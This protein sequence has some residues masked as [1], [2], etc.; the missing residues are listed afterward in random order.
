MIGT[1]TDSF[2]IKIGEFE[3]PFELLLDLV[4]RKKLP[5]N[6][7]SLSAIT[8]DFVAQLEGLGQTGMARLADFLLIASTL[9]LIKS[10]SLLPTLAV[11]EEETLGIEDLER[12]LK[13]YQVIKNAAA[14]LREKMGKTPIFF[15]AHPEQVV[16]FTPTAEITIIR[17]AATINDVLH[18]LPKAERLPEVQVTK[19]ITLEEMITDLAKRIERAMATSFRDLVKD[20]KDKINVIVGFLALLELVK[21]GVIE[22]KQHQHFAE[23]NIERSARGATPR[24]T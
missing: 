22:V 13:T 23:I 12:R 17:L 18:H 1:S 10:L 4:E 5:I 20:K 2:A 16:V 15:R 14:G 7:V 9:M 6:Q 8:D 24:Y 21:R 19:T 11:S 3:G